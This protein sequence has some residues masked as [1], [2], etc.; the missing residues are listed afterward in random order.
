MRSF[1]GNLVVVSQQMQDAMD[2]KVRPM[3]LLGFLLL[4]RLFLDERRTNH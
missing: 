4:C 1:S 2:H 3:R